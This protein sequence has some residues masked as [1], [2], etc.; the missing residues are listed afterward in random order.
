MITASIPSLD[1]NTDQHDDDGGKVSANSSL[2]TLL[3]I[4]LQSR[5]TKSHHCQVRLFE[6]NLQWAAFMSMN[7][8]IWYAAAI[9]VGEGNTNR[10]AKTLPRRFALRDLF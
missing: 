1:G 7:I 10:L 9:S 3:L 2:P 4:L 8:K 5:P 6:N